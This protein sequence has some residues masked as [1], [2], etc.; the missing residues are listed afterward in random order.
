MTNLLETVIEA[1]DNRE[2][3]AERYKVA[4]VAPTCFYY[5]ADLF[6]SL[7]AHPRIDLQVYFCSDEGLA[8]KDVQSMYLSDSKW[9]GE[10]EFLEGYRYKFV[11]NFSPWDSYL[12]PL[13]GLINLGIWKEFRTTK[14]QMVILMSWMNP[15]WW[16]A[17]AACLWYRIPYFYMTDANFQGESLKSNWKKWAK[18]LF[19]GKCLFPLASGF[20]CAGTA[21]KTLYRQYAV[22]EEKLF[23]FAYSWGY[24]KLIEIQEEYLSRRAELRDRF[25]IPQDS[26]VVLY[27]GRF[28]GIK[29]IF[30][31]VSAYERMDVP[32]KTLVMVGDGPL[33]PQLNQ[34][35]E[36]REIDSVWFTGFQSRNDLPEYYAIADVLVLPSG[37]ETWGIVVSEALC[38]GLPVIVSDQVGAGS[39]LVQHESNGF[40]FPPGD[41]DSLTAYLEQVANLSNEERSA[42]RAKSLELITNWSAMDLGKALDRCFDSVAPTN[43]HQ[44][45]AEPPVRV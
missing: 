12:K 34:M 33:R 32:N 38:F 35:I 21:N 41:V 9:G 4:I 27:C 16:L 8:A 28:T 7:A 31:L 43:L 30:D 45:T 44:H 29:N 36:S 1:A 2:E 22:P 5:Q 23:P 24:E 39:D 3:G 42:M 11:P 40:V 25:G 6:R 18:I 26:F 19:L 14:P 13:I 15:T 17:I 37:R 10:N 20:L